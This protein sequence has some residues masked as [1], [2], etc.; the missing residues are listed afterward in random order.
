MSILIKGMEMP[1][2]CSDCPMLDWDLD[3]IKCKVTGRHF[4]VKEEPFGARRMNDCPLIELPP[5]GR[6][7]DADALE[8]NGWYLM[9]VNIKDGKYETANLMIAPT[10]IEAD[11]HPPATP[12]EQVWTEV[13][14]EDGE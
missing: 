13:F 4:K 7:I 1:K 8:S 5:H 2:S 3:Y 6:L 10:V 9:R 12:F 11:Y 14:G